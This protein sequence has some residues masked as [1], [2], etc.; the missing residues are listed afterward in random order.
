M[1]TVGFQFLNIRLLDLIR[2]VRS[3]LVHPP[4]FLEK[5]VELFSG[6]VWWFQSKSRSRRWCCFDRSGFQ[7]SWISGE[8]L[9]FYARSDYSRGYPRPS[10]W[11]KILTLGPWV[12]FSKKGT[13]YDF[14][15]R[16]LQKHLTRRFEEQLQKKKIKQHNIELVLQK[17]RLKL[18][19]L[20]EV[21]FWPIS[22]LKVAGRRYYGECKMWMWLRALRLDEAKEIFGAKFANVQPHSVVRLIVLAY[23]A[24][25]GLRWQLWSMDLSAGGHL[26]HSASVNFSGQTYNFV[27]YSVDPETELLD[28]DAI[29]QRRPKKFSLSWLWRVLQPTL[30]SL[31]FQNSM[32]SCW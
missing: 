11:Y 26:T 18:S 16:R 29:L 25:D 22:M 31:I 15:P 8:R 19:W 28:F 21:L 14:W 4:I 10:K 9:V 17:Y 1:D 27:S 32:K 24:F 20:L 6:K 5:L 30:I 23:M 7:P 2:K 3:I 12:L 13:P